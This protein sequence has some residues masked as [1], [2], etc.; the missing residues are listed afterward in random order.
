MSNIRKALMSL[1]SVALLFG[2]TACSDSPMTAPG[3]TADLGPA[4]AAKYSSPRTKNG[5]DIKQ[6]YPTLSSQTPKIISIGDTTVQTF[7]VKPEKGSLVTFEKTSGDIIAIP[8]NTLCDPNKNGYGPTE[9]LKPCI[10]ATSS[11]TFEARTW[12]DSTGRPHAEFSPNVRFSPLAPEP[13]RLYFQDEELRNYTTLYIP[14]CNAF[15]V[16]I[17]EGLTDPALETYVTPL[18]KGGF[19]VYRTLRHFSGYTVTAD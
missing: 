1:A 14:Y 19:W 10:L 7:V 9:W 18:D 4:S 15:N 16:C 11:I 3:P 12:K 8:A 13:V 2:A 5:L 17:N 6:L